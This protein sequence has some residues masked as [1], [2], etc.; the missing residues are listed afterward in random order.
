MQAVYS[1]LVVCLGSELTCYTI[2]AAHR[3]CES[4][5]PGSGAFPEVA[6]LVPTW[7]SRGLRKSVISAG[8]LLGVTPFRVL[9]AL[10]LPC[11]LSP[12]GL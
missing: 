7:R 10:L 8:F 3:L 1:F 12:L 4:P 2:D 6:L 11:L 5:V 9:I